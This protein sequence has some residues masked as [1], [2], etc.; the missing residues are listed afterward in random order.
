MDGGHPSV[1]GEIL[2]GQYMWEILE[3]THPEVLG[4]VNPNNQRIQELFGDQ[5]GY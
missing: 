5:G 1:S 3:R 4:P 2:M